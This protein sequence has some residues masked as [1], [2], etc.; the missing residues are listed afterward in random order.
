MVIFRLFLA[1]LLVLALIAAQE[2]DQPFRTTVNVVVAPAIVTDRDGNYING[3]QPQ[4]FRL[5]DN[6]QAQNIKVDISFVPISMVVAIQSNSAAEPVMPKVQKIGPLFRSLVVG[7][8][9]EVALLSFDGKVQVLQDFTNDTDKLE[10]GLKKL[11]PGSRLSSLNDAVVAASR[12]LRKRPPDRRRVLLLISETRDNGS[13]AKVRDA[14]TDLQFDNVAVYT[15]N[16]N[17]L[18]TSMLAKP[19]RPRPDPLPPAARPLPA[20]VPP[21]PENAAQVYG[22]P[23]NSANFVPVLVEIF[24]QVKGIFVDNPIEVYTRFTG[25]RER[26]FVTERDLEN[27]ISSIGTELH[28][29]YLISYNPTNKSEGGFHDIKVSLPNHPEYRVRTRPGYWVAAQPE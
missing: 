10:Q 14:L 1:G 22:N 19:E 15:V 24:R 12:M 11:R 18:V 4:D 13:S 21:T 17:R 7:D 27:A 26:S 3:L 5:T 28:A 9:G 25:G 8:Q 6:E 23:A 2:P 16:I 29:E 20:G